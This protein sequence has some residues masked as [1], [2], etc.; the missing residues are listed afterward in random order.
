V[1]EDRAARP[2]VPL[3]VET[4]RLVLRAPHP[5]FAESVNEAIR[6]SFAEL[7]RWMPW[8][9]EIPTLEASREQQRAG[10]SAFL[11]R[12][13][14]PVVMFCGPRVVGCSG[15]HR[16]DWSVPRFEIGYWVR[17]PDCGQGYA[18]ETVEALERLAFEGLGARRVE[19]RADP[20]NTRSRA[21]PERLGYECEGILRN[22]ARAPD[23]RIRD[24]VVYAKI[25]PT[26]AGGGTQDV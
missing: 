11:A 17:T 9:A 5:D 26:R 20:L 2:A 1:T 19:I 18:T 12:D 3:E 16:M 4:P 23:G 14:L 6:E 22:E 10:R 24:T 8:A 7:H 15:L 25:R 21:V 13:D